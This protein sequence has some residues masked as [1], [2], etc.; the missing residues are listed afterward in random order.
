[1]KRMEENVRVGRIWK[2]NYREERSVQL[3][4]IIPLS[5]SKR[6]K[7]TVTTNIFLDKT[8]DF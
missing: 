4:E 2:T 1:M 3:F 8:T 5:F 7:N 6:K